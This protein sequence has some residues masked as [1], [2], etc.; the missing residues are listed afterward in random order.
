[1]AELI[2]TMAE[3][4]GTMAELI[5]TAALVPLVVMVGLNRRSG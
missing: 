2:A 4:V 5:L 1:M 3:L